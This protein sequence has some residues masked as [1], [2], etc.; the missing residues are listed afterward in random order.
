MISH[1]ATAQED[2]A[3]QGILSMS[4]TS[5]HFIAFAHFK[6]TSALGV[7]DRFG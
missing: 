2:C 7:L 5:R 1:L 3:R 4:N 6:N